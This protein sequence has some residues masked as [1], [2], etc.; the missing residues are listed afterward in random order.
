M[1]NYP[2][3]IY[4]QNNLRLTEKRTVRQF[5]A[6][7]LGTD[8]TTSPT[9][10]PNYA[11]PVLDWINERIVEG[12][13]IFATTPETPLTVIDSN[14]FDFTTTGTVNHTLT[15]NVKISNNAGNQLSIQPNGLFVP[16]VNA[17]S[18]SDLSTCSIENLG[19]VTI[20][21]PILNQVLSFNGIDWINV[22]LPDIPD[23]YEFSCT[24]LSACSINSLGDINISSPNLGQALIYNGTEW[25]N[26]ILPSNTYTGDS[27]ITQISNNFRLGGTLLQDTS[28]NGNNNTYEIGIT[29]AKNFF[30]KGGASPGSAGSSKSFF[31]FDLPTNYNSPDGYSANLY[32]TKHNINAYPLTNGKSIISNNI[33]SE[34]N[35]T[36]N[37]TIDS[38]SIFSG[39]SYSSKFN[40]TS[41]NINLTKTQGSA[42]YTLLR[43]LYNH[44]TILQL[45]SG[46]TNINE[47]IT[48]NKF[49]NHGILTNY[50]NAFQSN[51][52]TEFVQF[53]IGNAKG[54]SD[55][56]TSLK[57]P[58]TYAIWQEGVDDK[59]LF[60]G[61]IILPTISTYANDTAAGVGGLI[62]GTL[63]KT[64]TGEIRIKL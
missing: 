43:H 56:T 33:Y 58:N 12:D 24:E 63:Y 55:T 62:S 13:I 57:M 20:T 52:F 41:N 17:F 39:T 21:S 14:S 54:D 28:I 10:R 53:Y 37:T 60:K 34:Y 49:V 4:L 32:I 2:K 42:G 64:A 36:A 25:V 27:G 7:I 31:S 18:C 5:D 47:F 22:T 19:N 15:G 26:Q 29:N 11:I 35:I 44:V 61:K 9:Q 40:T 51:E 50:N 30:V 23:P 16:T 48:F 59:V 6:R 45:D 46:S 8:N 38:G 1:P 3:H